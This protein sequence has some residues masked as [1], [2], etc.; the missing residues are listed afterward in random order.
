MLRTVIALAALAALVGATTAYAVDPNPLQSAYW[1][2]ENG[3]AGTKVPA[4]PNTVLDSINANH[5][6][7]YNDVTGPVYSSLVP[8][9]IIPQTGA[10]NNL[11]LRFSPNQDIYTLGG[12][13]PP[14]GKY[15][16]NPIIN[17]GFTLEAAF[18]PSALNRYQAIVGKDGK[19]NANMPEQT[20]ALKMRG[21]T[22]ELQIE[23]FDGTNTIHGVRSLAP[24]S[25][26]QWYYAAVVDDGTHLSLYLDR[27]DG[28]GYVLQGTDPNPLSGALAQLDTSWAIG[29]GMYDNNPTDWFDGY[30]DE[31]RLSNSALDPSQFLFTPEPGTLL[32]LALGGLGLLRRGR[33]A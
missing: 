17:N 2:M 8:T 33:R 28:A 1:R 21:D 23:L 9:P 11:S 15:I 24:L 16:N 32:L 29:R 27:N 22:N 30:I 14:D 26:D 12:A 3:T 13:A 6:Q 10:A 18:M 5:M 7:T 19:P 4:G 25:A 20:L 31:V